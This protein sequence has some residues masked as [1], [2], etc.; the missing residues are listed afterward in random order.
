MPGCPTPGYLVDQAIAGVSA[1]LNRG[2]KIGNP[3]ADMVD[4]RSPA[5]QE[6]P[7]GTIRVG[8]GQ[9]LDS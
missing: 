9:Q 4:A 1:R 7:D 5:S 6:F 2:V 3:L 8:G